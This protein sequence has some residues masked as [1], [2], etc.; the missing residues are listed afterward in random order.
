MI[1]KIDEFSQIENYK[2]KDI[3]YVRIC[4]LLNAYGCKY[5]FALFYRQLDDSGNVTAIISSLDK[6]ITVSFNDELCNKD[7]IAEFISVVGYI[8]VLCDESLHISNAYDSGAVMKT[9]KKIELPCDYKE[10]N[11][12][13]YLF[14]LYNF[15]DYGENGFDSWY[16][17]ISHRIRHG[18]AKAVTLNIDSVIVSSAIFSS[19]YNGDAIITAVKTNPDYRGK[20]Y[21][22]SLVSAMC[23]DVSGDVYL[24]REQ[25]KNEA[26]YKKLGFENIGNWRIY[27]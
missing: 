27:K 3:Y 6:D 22:S 24:M 20:G 9:A 18:A 25:D 7:E 19:I 26:F 10:I 1:E 5:P 12:Y 16:V 23:C 2:I 17:D 4:S 15:V 13:P 21:G 14:D 8:T 11:E